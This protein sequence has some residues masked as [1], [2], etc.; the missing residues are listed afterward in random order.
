MFNFAGNDSSGL[1]SG[2]NLS[3]PMVSCTQYSIDSSIKLQPSLWNL[4]LF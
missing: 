1:I 2:I 3:K 4:E